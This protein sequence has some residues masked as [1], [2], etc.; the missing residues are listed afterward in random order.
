VKTKL[1]LPEGTGVAATAGAT[2]AAAMSTT[3]IAQV[4]NPRSSVFIRV[5]AF[6]SRNSQ[7]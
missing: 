7:L 1:H 4:L 5:P 6:G 2:A 3:P